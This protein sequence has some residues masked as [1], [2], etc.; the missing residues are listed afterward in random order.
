MRL[1]KA[2][3]IATILFLPLTLSCKPAVEDVIRPPAHAGPGD[4]YP[5]DPTQLGDMLDG[6]L[7]KADDYTGPRPRAVIA[8]H[9]GYA[10]SG[11][12]AA[13][14]F[15][16]LLRFAPDIKRVILLAPS[17]YAGFLG[18]V[19]NAK[20]YQTP[21]GV[22]PLD[23]DAVKKLRASG[24]SW[25]TNETA[26]TK[27]HADEME[28][29]FLQKVLPH[30]K[31]VPM[32]VGE[33]DA[34]TLSGAAKAISS[35]L[36]DKTVLVVSSDFTHFGPNYSY[37]PKFKKGVEQGLKDMDGTAVRLITQGDL[38]GFE[39][40]LGETQSTI[41]GRYPILLALEVL[42]QGGLGVTGSLLR[43][44]TSGH[45]TGD[46]T[47]SVS[48]SA[49]ALWNGEKGTATPGSVQPAKDVEKG[50]A[51]LQN[52]K[53]LSDAEERTLLKLARFTLEK[54]V[55]EGKD[56]FKGDDLNAFDLTPSLKKNFGVFVT[57]NEN[58]RLRGCIG[59]ITPSYPLY[60]GVIEN[61]MNAA[62]HDPRFDPVVGSELKKITVE[63]LGHV[64]AD[65]RGKPR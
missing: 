27:E 64:A 61:A 38:Q 24:F 41:C 65:T 16:A 45:L 31:L 57:L 4:F 54:F 48:Y 6:F 35:I 12:T 10:Y 63:I 15:K 59:N 25:T 55:A 21:L 39:A 17:H 11:Q 44:E 33:L 36:D 8:P 2:S 1:R 60:K 14:S 3:F 52:E 26:E 32:V 51:S 53:F 62:A 43:Y 7:A 34:E 42:H 9:A 22:Y 49:I 56:R 18:V 19:L 29:P 28:I 20:S 58:G 47:N 46:W 13:Y 37:L 40:F 30:A 23:K 5:S 50:G